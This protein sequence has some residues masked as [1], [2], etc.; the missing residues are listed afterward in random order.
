MHQKLIV[1]IA[2]LCFVVSVTFLM[3]KDPVKLQKINSVT[4]EERIRASHSK[5][6]WTG[7]KQHHNNTLCFKNRFSNVLLIIIYNHPLYD[8]VNLL[9]QFYQPVFPDIYFCGEVANSTLDV[10]AAGINKGIY[11]YK[12][13]A[14][15]IKWKQGYM[16][17][18]YINDDVILNYWNLVRFGFNMTKVG[19]SSNQFGKV[20]T[21]DEMPRDWYWWISPYGFKNCKR[22]IEEIVSLAKQYDVYDKRLRIFDENGGN[23]HYCHNG[24]SDIVFIPGHLAEDFYDIATTFYKYNV[25]LEI[26]IPTI[27]RFIAR[28]DDI[29]TLHGLYLPGDVRKKD[30]RVTDS[31]YFWTIYLR[32]DSLWFIHPFKLHHYEDHNRD[33][34]IELMKRIMIRKT[35]ELS[36][37]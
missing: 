22:A 31:R 32:K 14:D 23:R 29:T 10:H 33:L 8:S 13:I 2:G 11:G 15:A 19:E 7:T 21:E 35:S 26:T 27:I 30:P 3:F 28:N 9:R 16:G 24:R 25:F 12:C 17:Y 6:K 5:R 20:D 18:L 37:C 36:R 1:V 34:S 4:S